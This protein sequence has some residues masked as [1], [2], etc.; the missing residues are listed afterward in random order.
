MYN[1]AKLNRN[2]LNSDLDFADLKDDI[3]K[4]MLK[5]QT[6][7]LL[8]LINMFSTS[9][10]FCGVDFSCT[11]TG[12]TYTSIA[13]CAQMKLEPI[14]ICPKSV[15][16]YWKDICDNFN[17]KAKTIIN[18]EAIKKGNDLN[19]NMEKTKSDIITTQEG[20][21]IW[22][23]IDRNKNIIIFD[24][25]HRC[26]SHTTLNGKLLLSTKNLCRIL[27]LSAT[28][29]QNHKDFTIFGYMLGFYRQ[30]TNGKKWIDGIIREDKLKLSQGPDT[31][32]I[33]YICEK[34]AR[35]SYSDMTKES[36]KN[37]ISA[38]CYDLDDK[39]LAAIE[40]EYQQLEHKGIHLTNQLSARQHIE[41]LKIPIFI[42]LA[43]KYI[44]SGRSVVI[45]VNFIN[46]LRKLVEYFCKKRID[47]GYISGEQTIENRNDF[48]TSFQNND[49]K[50]MICMLAAGS[51]SIS[52][53]DLDGNHPRVSLIS[54]SFSGKDLC[55]ALGRIYRS[56][57]KSIVEQ[58]IIFC[59]Q[60]VERNI[61]EK[62][63]NKIQFLNNFANSDK[64]DDKM[65]DLQNFL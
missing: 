40:N 47:C 12:K 32:L 17:V 3:E 28:I 60:T 33:S 29:A 9:N 39:Q 20:K 38:Q 14:I 61:C 59:D 7:H 63:K 58:K 41:Q 2:I 19:D 30:M 43:E 25:A 44:E 57:V 54:P 5:Y 53:H 56:G 24:E 22:N 42:D 49:I 23:G 13:L 36:N 11:G 55:Q 4:K 45:F 37:F 31:Q 64:F 8:T 35:M 52:L 34:G 15:I 51:E 1:K 16:C 62:L 65:F 48:I 50:I 21:F 10:I 27:L 26:K 6:H 46:S 18:Y